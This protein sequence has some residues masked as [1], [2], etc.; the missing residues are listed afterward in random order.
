MS[1]QTSERFEEIS[2]AIFVPLTTTVACSINR[3]TMRPRRTS[4]AC[5]RRSPAFAGITARATRV[6]VGF[7]IPELCGSGRKSTNGPL[8]TKNMK[9]TKMS[10]QLRRHDAEAHI[11]GLRGVSQEAD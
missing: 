9:L 10:F 4:V 3:R 8:F 2:C 7:L 5:A 1:R 11:H 6:A